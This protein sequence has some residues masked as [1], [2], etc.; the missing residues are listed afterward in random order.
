MAL[1]FGG[2]EITPQLSSNST[3]SSNIPIYLFI[4]LSVVLQVILSIFKRL[5]FRN[6]NQY[7]DQLRQAL[8]TGVR[9]V[10]REIVIFELFFLFLTVTLVHQYFSMEIKSDYEV[11]VGRPFLLALAMICILLHQFRRNHKLR[12]KASFK[13]HFA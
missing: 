10:Y 4:A 2:T 6:K 3:F 11:I 7:A 1:F 13:F 12:F 5:R 8:I 9:N